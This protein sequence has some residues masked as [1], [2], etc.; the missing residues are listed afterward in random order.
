LP[1]RVSRRVGALDPWRDVCPSHSNVT[2]LISGPTSPLRSL[3]MPRDYLVGQ[4]KI[5]TD[6]ICLTIK[7]RLS[8]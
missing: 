7:E 4:A 5:A 1:L 8:L 2:Q 3:S 6:A